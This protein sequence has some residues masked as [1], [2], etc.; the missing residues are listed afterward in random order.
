MVLSLNTFLHKDL[1]AGF[2]REAVVVVVVTLFNEGKNILQSLTDKL[3]V[4]P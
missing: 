3:V 4:L 1:K 2:I